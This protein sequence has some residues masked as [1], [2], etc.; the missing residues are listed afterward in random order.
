[1]PNVI[2]LTDEIIDARVELNRGASGKW[3]FLLDNADGRFDDEFAVG[4]EVYIKTGYEEE[5]IDTISGLTFDVDYQREDVA[6]EGYDW[7]DYLVGPIIDDKEYYDEDWGTI[8]KDLIDSYAPKVN[9]DEISEIGVTSGGVL[10]FHKDSLWDTLQTIID[11]IG[12]DLMID[13]DKKA[14]LIKR[15]KELEDIRWDILEE[16]VYDYSFRTEKGKMV[17][18]VVIRGSE[19][20]IIDYFVDDNVRDEFWDNITEYWSTFQSSNEVFLSGLIY[21]GDTA[22]VDGS[23]YTT[24]EPSIVDFETNVKTDSVN[25]DTSIYV[26]TT[27]LTDGYRIRLYNENGD[28]WIELLDPTSSISKHKLTELLPDTWYKVNIETSTDFIKVAVNGQMFISEI[29]DDMPSEGKVCLVPKDGI[30]T[31]YDFIDILTSTP[32]LGGANDTDSQEIFGMKVLMLDRPEVVLNTEANRLAEL[33]LE[34]RKFDVK[35]GTIELEGTSDIDLGDSIRWI[36]DGETY[37]IVEVNHRFDIEGWDTTIQVNERI[38][39]LEAIIGEI[40]RQALRRYI[41][42]PIG[43]HKVVERVM[44]PEEVKQIIEDSP[45]RIVF[46]CTETPPEQEGRLWFDCNVNKFKRWSD[47]LDDWEIVGDET[48]AHLDDMFYYDTWDNAP[49]HVEGRLFYATDKEELYR[50]TSEVWLPVSD[51]T[52]ASNI[53]WTC[54]AEPDP[55]EEGMMWFDCNVNKLKRYDGTNW[56]VVGDETSEHPNDIIYYDTWANRPDDVGKEGRLFFATDEDRKKFYRSDGLNWVEVSDI[57]GFNPQD[58][59]WLNDAP[60]DAHHVKFTSTEHGQEPSDV[61]HPDYALGSVKSSWTMGVDA[62]YSNDSDVD[63]LILASVQMNVDSGQ[64]AKA[65]FKIDEITH[66]KVELRNTGDND[67]IYST[68]MVGGIVPDGSDY[69]VD[70]GG[71]IGNPLFNILY[72]HEAE[73]RTED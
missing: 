4:Q 58:H 65:K 5:E 29:I 19:E 7:T 49:S 41:T 45:D 72:A 18:R 44:T 24:I 47:E 71:T 61:H 25:F 37:N 27:N 39:E 30:E 40:N 38:P 15:E 17:N 12:Y 46:R 64:F 11:E 28:G 21:D 22:G 54:S 57:T 59:D 63:V 23:L 68:A 55:K 62:E 42:S 67:T 52:K 73:I 35:R 1:M 48:V 2:T 26:L 6:V 16:D 13:V 50:S 8:I 66:S 69:E 10:K 32:I 14:H 34:R 51:I 20:R 56:L 31:T 70:T 3:Y 9:T 53:T 36:G 60:E 33:E 43:V